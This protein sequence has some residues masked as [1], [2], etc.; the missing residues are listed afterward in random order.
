MQAVTS[1]CA[2]V[3]S[4]YASASA[5]QRAKRYRGARN[6]VTATSLRR[7]PR[8]A[9]VRSRG[10]LIRP[11]DRGRG[12]PAPH[13]MYE[14][15]LPTL[16]MRHRCKGAAVPPPS[17]VR[18]RLLR[19]RSELRV[20][21]RLLDLRALEA[22]R[23]LPR[24]RVDGAHL[25][26]ATAHSPGPPPH[27]G[28]GPQGCLGQARSGLNRDAVAVPPHTHALQPWSCGGAG[29]LLSS[30]RLPCGDPH[31]PHEQPQHGTGAASHSLRSPASTW[32]W[33]SPVH[34]SRSQSQ[35]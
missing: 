26:G 16:Q 8:T 31:M 19:R 21:H 25:Q 34:L 12:G 14:G 29:L 10:V 2:G 32:C 3:A 4:A 28:T 22:A 23:L 15:W 27:D 9:L 20:V 6:D 13:C 11:L 1:S 35:D 33:V 5:K 18:L 30:R 24:T 7:T 17:R